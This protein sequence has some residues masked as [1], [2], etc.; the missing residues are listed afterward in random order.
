MRTGNIYK[1]GHSQSMRKDIDLLD[2]NSIEISAMNGND[3]RISTSVGDSFGLPYLFDMVDYQA[4]F[5]NSQKLFNAL[6]DCEFNV[7]TI[8]LKQNESIFCKLIQP[9]DVKTIRCN[10]NLFVYNKQHQVYLNC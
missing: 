2:K 4:V 9:F 3:T 7:N 8:D 6:I 10:M 5:E 1:Y